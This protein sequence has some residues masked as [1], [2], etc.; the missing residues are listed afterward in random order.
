[1][2]DRNEIPEECDELAQILYDKD[3]EDL[4]FEKK[5]EISVLLLEHI[6]TRKDDAREKERWH[7]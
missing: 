7:A 4:S 6:E 2:I 3:Y 1:M 5:I